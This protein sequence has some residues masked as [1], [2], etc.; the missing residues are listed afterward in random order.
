[1]AWDLSEKI[2]IVGGLGGEVGLVDLNTMDCRL[3]S[4]EELLKSLEVIV[5]S[6]VR[7]IILKMPRIS[8][9]FTLIPS[10]I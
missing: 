10:K 8:W 3:S 7:P 1:M 5:Y 6:S 9:P 4:Q 2:L